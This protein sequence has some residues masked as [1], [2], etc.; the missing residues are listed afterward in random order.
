MED[1]VKV[2]QPFGDADMYAAVFDGHGGAT[3]SERASDRLHTILS[4]AWSR[5]PIDEALR[6]AFHLFEAEVAEQRAGAVAVVSVLAGGLVTVANI[7]DCHALVVS[8]RGHELLT[9]DHRLDN[10]DELRR[11]LAAGAIIRGPYM[12]LPEGVGVMNARAFGDAAFKRIGLIAEP[13]IAS[14]T[15]RTDDRWLV[16]G[17][18]GVWDPLKVE[19]IAAIVR[20]MSTAAGAA[21]RLLHMAVSAG[22][23]NVSTVVIRLESRYFGADRPSHEAF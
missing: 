11:V 15:L 17:S 12:C 5:E 18:D 6:S 19:D 7:G 10:K 2:V 23:D 9:E 14:R 3:V 16:L 20:P 1:F 8:E 4:S 22:Q 13:A 21:D